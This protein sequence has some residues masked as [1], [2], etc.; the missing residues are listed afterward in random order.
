MR[1]V[2]VTNQTRGIVI[3]NH[4][5]VAETSWTRMVG[6]LGRAGVDAGAGLWIKPSSGVHTIGMKFPI[7]VIGLDRDR[8]VIK[9]W[10]NLVPGRITSISTRLR[11]VVELSAGRIAECQVQLGDKLDIQEP[12]TH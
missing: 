5:E 1:V 8:N 11:S 6:L 9:L 4:V 2:Q 3:G 12:P 10:Q 7:D